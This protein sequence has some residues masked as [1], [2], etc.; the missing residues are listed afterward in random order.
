MY[1]SLAR[2]MALRLKNVVGMMVSI[3]IHKNCTYGRWTTLGCHPWML[4][5]DYTLG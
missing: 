3:S 1:K 2:I 5:N 4:I